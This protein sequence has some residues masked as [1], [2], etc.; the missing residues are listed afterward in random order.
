M[1]DTFYFGAGPATLPRVVLQNIQNELLNYKDTGLSVLELAHR[2]EEFA[3]IKDYAEK[4]LRELMQISEE[5]A[6]LFMHGGATSQFSM[7]PLNFLKSQQTADYVCT[8]LWSQKAYEEAKKFANVNKIEALIENSKLAIKPTQHWPINPDSKYI[9]YCEN[10]T[11]NGVKFADIPNMKSKQIVCDMTSSILTSPIDINKYGLVY[12]GAQKNLGIAGL[13]VVIVNKEFLSQ[14]N[15][16]V[17]RLYDYKLCAQYDS[18]VNTPPI[19][20][21]YVLH[22]LLQWVNDEGGVVEMYKRRKKQA[23]LIYNVIDS[24]ELYINN[25]EKE[26][27]SDINI[28]FAIN[29]LNL[30]ERFIQE[31][32]ARCLLGLRG[33]KTLGGI[34]VS[35]YNAI[36]QEGVTALV[37]FMQQFESSLGKNSI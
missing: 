3:A 32:S 23:M 14:T 15:E 11:I 19:F 6:V 1:Q 28:P 34:R 37:D 5:Y 33:H 25:V 20:A 10:E 22:L 36:P 9:H 4:L 24:S 27:R 30:L 26:F 31:A 8:G 2:S 13:C 35:L 7:L 16:I 21:I 29:D 17:P 18:L 12:A